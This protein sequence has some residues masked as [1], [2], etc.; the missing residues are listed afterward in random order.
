MKKFSFNE[1]WI[2]LMM[3]CVSSVSYSILINGAPQGFIRPSRGIRQRDPPSP[4][5]FLLCTEGLHGLLTQSTSR[6][7][8]NGFSLSRRSPPLTHILFVDDGL[9]FCRSNTE[10]CQKILEILQTYKLSL[11]QQINKAKTT[12]FFS[13]SLL[14]SGG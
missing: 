8:I 7:D 9:L 10:E 12:I 1:R 6:G 14:K 5:L 3:L 11:G 4:F 2:T 13:H